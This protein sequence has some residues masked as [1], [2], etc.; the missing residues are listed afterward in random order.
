MITNQEF[1]KKFGSNFRLSEPDTCRT[2]IAEAPHVSMDMAFMVLLELFEPRFE[3]NSDQQARSDMLEFWASQ[4]EHPL[5]AGI[6]PTAQLV[7][8]GLAV[9]VGD[10]MKL[11]QF[12]SKFPGQYNALLLASRAADNPT[13]KI[14]TLYQDIVHAWESGQTMDFA[15]SMNAELKSL[16]TLH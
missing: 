9:G 6:L 15:E 14:Q 1:I 10:A 3:G 5:A 8:D 2:L 13:E 16:S 7:I 11:M 4:M 12:V